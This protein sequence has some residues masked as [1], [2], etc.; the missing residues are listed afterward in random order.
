MSRGQLRWSVLSDVRAAS[1]YSL[2]GPARPPA[3]LTTSLIL[4]NTDGF[5]RTNGL[6]HRLL[7]CAPGTSQSG[8]P[9]YVSITRP[10]S[11]HFQCH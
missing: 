9:E 4:A 10:L 3:A 8:F 6:S 1:L 2:D 5:V 11:T 7:P